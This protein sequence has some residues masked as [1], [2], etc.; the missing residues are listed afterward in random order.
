MSKIK[1]TLS[2]LASS[3]YNLGCR[4]PK[5][6]ENIHDCSEEV[7]KLMNDWVVAEANFDAADIAIKEAA[8]KEGWT[9]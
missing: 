7:R 9:E 6:D 3:R 8:E 5:Y 2:D 4:L 1:I